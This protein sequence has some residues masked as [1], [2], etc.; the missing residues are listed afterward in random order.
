ME[1]KSAY[2]RISY[3]GVLIWESE[4]ATKKIAS[5]L[6]THII[7]LKLRKMYNLAVNLELETD[8]GK[9]ANIGN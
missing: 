9:H 7:I 4:E 6:I 8:L 1:S 3:G 2:A 5:L